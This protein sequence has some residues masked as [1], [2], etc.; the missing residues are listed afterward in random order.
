[1]K[2]LS[3]PPALVLACALAAG[4]LSLLGFVQLRR[5]REQASQ[6]PV[7]PGE[8]NLSTADDG[9]EPDAS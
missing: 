6:L 9:G 1:M 7:E 5:F 3:F 2:L 8:T 4:A